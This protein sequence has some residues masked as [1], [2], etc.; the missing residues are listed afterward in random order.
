MAGP[1]GALAIDFLQDIVEQVLVGDSPDGLDLDP[2]RGNV[3]PVYGAV[4]VGLEKCV[5]VV[6]ITVAAVGEQG[7]VA[8]TREYAAEGKQPAVVRPAHDRLARRRRQRLGERQGGVVAVVAELVA[9]IRGEE[10]VDAVSGE[11]VR[12]VFRGEILQVDVEETHRRGD[13]ARIGEEREKRRT[14]S[15]VIA[16]AGRSNASRIVPTG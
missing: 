12:S 11:I 7:G 10:L 6:E 5:H 1:R 14:S 15:A 13:R 3:A 8:F 9:V 16:A 2:I 4:A